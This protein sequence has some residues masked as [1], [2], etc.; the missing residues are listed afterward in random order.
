MSENMPLFVFLKAYYCYEKWPSK[1]K[2]F[3]ELGEAPMIILEY[4]PSSF[5][6]PGLSLI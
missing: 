3:Y 4:Q 1:K 2:S 5:I 6:R